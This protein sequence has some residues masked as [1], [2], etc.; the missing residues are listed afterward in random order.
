[1]TREAVRAEGTPGGFAGVYPV[2]RAL[3][4]SGRARRGWFVAGLGA[5]RSSRCPAPSIGSAPTKPVARR[6]RAHRGARRDR[7]R[8]AVRRRAELARATAAAADRLVRPAP[9]VVL[10]DG[11]CVAYVG[12]GRRALLTF[13]RDSRPKNPTRG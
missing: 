3:E 9:H 5:L 11:E 4:E 2:L 7:S 10:V 8:A 12:A 6:A 1:M 13:R